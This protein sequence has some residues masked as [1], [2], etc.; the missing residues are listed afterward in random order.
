VEDEDVW[1]IELGRGSG[2]LLETR[3]TFG[4]RGEAGMND[5]QG[6]VSPEPRSPRPV[7]L[8]HPAGAQWREDL[9]WAEAGP[10]F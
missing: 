9:V 7:H 8:A 10:G 6:D 2:F 1:V 4:V 3:E 5:L